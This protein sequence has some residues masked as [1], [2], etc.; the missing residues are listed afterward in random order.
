MRFAQH[1]CK[2]NSSFKNRV[3]I[4]YFMT[5][6]GINWKRII[7]LLNQRISSYEQINITFFLRHYLNAH[8][9]SFTNWPINASKSADKMTC[10]NCGIRCLA[11]TPRSRCQS[12][13][14]SVIMPVKYSK[15]LARFLNS[16]LW[17]TQPK[18]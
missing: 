8:F 16:F 4:I 15:A 9:L 17:I 7:Q 5:L 1:V 14:R 2:E 13:N 10:C 18:N 6:N 11:S 3:R 12:T